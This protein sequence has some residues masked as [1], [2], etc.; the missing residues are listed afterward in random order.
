M[1]KVTKSIEKELQKFLD[2]KYKEG[3]SEEEREYLITEFMCQYNLK[4]INSS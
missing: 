3:M 1:N 4:K 2:E